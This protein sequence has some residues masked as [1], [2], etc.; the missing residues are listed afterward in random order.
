MIVLLNTLLLGTRVSGIAAPFE[1]IVT[2]TAS[3]TGLTQ[4]R[5]Q[6]TIWY[7]TAGDS[8]GR[9]LKTLAVI[10]ED[11]A[12]PLDEGFKKATV[13]LARAIAG[14]GIRTAVFTQGAG[15]PARPELSMSAPPASGPS[16]SELPRNKLLLG[17]TFADRLRAF[18][19]DAIL[20]VPSAA[21]TPMSLVRARFLRRQAGGVPVAVLSLQA[22]EY[23]PAWLPLVRLARPDLVLTLSRR[24][25][26]VV[27]R[28]GLKA[29]VVRLGVD[30]AVFRPAERG[31]KEEV[32][33][34]YHIPDGK[35]IL[36]V[37]HV[38]PR[39]NLE[40][41]TR[42]ASAEGQAR[43]H[44]VIVA[45]TSTSRDPEVRRRLEGRPV[46][47]IDT[48]VERIEEI[49]R[50]ADCYVFP[51]FCP[52]GAIEMPLS[53]LEAL[54]SGLPVVTTIF[55]GIPD[56]L[57][58]GRGLFIAA[59]D[60]EFLE[61]LE[62]ALGVGDTAASLGVGDAAARDLVVD[63]TWEK[64]AAGLVEALRGLRQLR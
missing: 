8:I 53:V 11:L 15:A 3:I 19:A 59:S 26:R 47:F 43:R 21:A 41:L 64:A 44:L 1:V 16:W 61:K 25:C 14:L 49:Y 50:A 48:Y 45:S 54:A 46:T 30:S 36:H 10:S 37:G 2:T 55:G 35:V 24:T 60:R 22:R 40:L 20:Y 29:G 42:A 57:S 51:T 27:E 39:R 4:N 58:E 23:P 32:R 17:R 18:G 7:V 63:L 12:P 62:V 6:N 28:A 5:V 52:G 56:V 31:E 33:R 9:D 38:S 13:C 34:R